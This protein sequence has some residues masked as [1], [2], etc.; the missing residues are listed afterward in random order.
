MTP[1]FMTDQGYAGSLSLQ[2]LD[3]CWL[4]FGFEVLN[5]LYL[6]P[7]SVQMMQ[8]VFVDVFYLGCTLICFIVYC[9]PSTFV[10]G[11]GL[12][13]W[14]VCIL[15]V[16][17]QLLAWSSILS[18]SCAGLFRFDSCI[19]RAFSTFCVNP[20]VLLWL[21]FLELFCLPNDYNIILVSWLYLSITKSRGNEPIL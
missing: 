3:R 6:P 11:V 13:G 20:F 18:R 12:F 17:L 15:P 14:L 9:L 1:S 21:C 19:V 16:P 7:I 2:L 8:S 10:Y 4:G 5:G